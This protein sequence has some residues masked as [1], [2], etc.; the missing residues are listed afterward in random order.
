MTADH[1]TMLRHNRIDLAL[2]HLTPPRGEAR[3]LLIL[4]GLGHHSPRTRPEWTRSWSGP[5]AALDFTGHGDSTLPRG[6]G[7]SSELLMGDVDSALAHLGTATVVGF[8]LGA[9]VALLIAGA[10]PDL[11]HGAVLSDGP[12][13]N[14]GA[15]Q[16]TSVSVMPPGFVPDEAQVT[17]DPWALADLALELRPPDYATAFARLA[18]AASH[19]EEPLTVCA[20]SRAPWLD[21]VRGEPGVASSTDLAEAV[22][23]YR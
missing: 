5:I 3:A 23:R 7:Y 10:R 14:G 1:I 12:G 15:T 8:G 4:H 11:V 20:K 19:L 22:E 18:V 17:P 9:Y 21:A 16:P 13:L 2:H 6:G